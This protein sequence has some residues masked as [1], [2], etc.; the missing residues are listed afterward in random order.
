MELGEIPASR[1]KVCMTQKGLDLAHLRACL[2]QRA[3]KGVT[4]RMDLA[5]PQAA[6]A[7]IR[8]RTERQRVPNGLIARQADP[9][10]ALCLALAVLRPLVRSYHRAMEQSLAFTLFAVQVRYPGYQGISG[11]A[12]WPLARKLVVHLLVA[13]A[14]RPDD[15]DAGASDGEMLPPHARKLRQASPGVEPDEQQRG[16][17]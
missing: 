16:V 10:R 2:L 14:T 8:D 11:H 4:Q 15:R 3:R 7:E 12:L 17:A 5:G 13:L 9:N 6:L 1:A